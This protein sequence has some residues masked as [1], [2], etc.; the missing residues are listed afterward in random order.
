MELKATPH[1]RARGFVIEAQMEPGMGPTVNLLVTRGT[2]SIGNILLCGPYWGRVKALINDHGIKVRKAVPA[3]PVRCLGLSGVPKAGEPFMVLADEKLVRDIAEQRRAEIRDEQIVPQ[4]K[5]SLETIFSAMAADQR[6]ELRLILKCDTQ[7]SLEAIQKMLSEIKSEKVS[8]SI[9][10]A[11]VGN[12][13]ENDVMLASASNAIIFGFNVSK[14]EGVTRAEKSEGVEIRLYGII[15]DIL[16]QIKEAMSGMLKPET[17]EK[18]VG[19]AEVRQVFE[20]SKK[21][22]VA[23][24]LIVDGKASARCKSRV[25]RGNDILYEGAVFTL[26][27]FQDQVNEVR[28]GQECGIRL[29][30][31]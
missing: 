13:N 31:F 5:V 18:Y 10:L 27:R 1:V 9:V 11:A 6:L 21:G 8:V 23:G 4:K 19:R 24:C 30:N 20:I 12:V 15:Y 2:L 25:K 22:Q 3:T 16:D 28:E 14:E 7:G 29:D 26:K 17:R